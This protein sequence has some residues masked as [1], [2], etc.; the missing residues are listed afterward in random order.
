MTW[1]EA[2]K[3]HGFM[4]KCTIEDLLVSRLIPRTKPEYIQKPRLMKK[5]KRGGGK[6]RSSRPIN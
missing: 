6:Y 3:M 5:K 1:I 4:V 2:V